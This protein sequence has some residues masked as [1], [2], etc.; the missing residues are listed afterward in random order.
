MLIDTTPNLIISLSDFISFTIHFLRALQILHE[1]RIVHTR[2]QSN[3]IY[4]PGF[5]PRIAYF[6]QFL[7]LDSPFLMK[8]RNNYL[9]LESHIL[10]PPEINY[11]RCVN[12]HTFINFYHRFIKTHAHVGNYYMDYFTKPK[13]LQ[14]FYDFKQEIRE[15]NECWKNYLPSIDIYRFALIIQYKILP[16]VKM[17]EKSRNFLHYQFLFQATNPFY[18]SRIKNAKDL[19][20]LFE[21]Y[22]LEK[23]II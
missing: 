5:K 13:L 7:Y 23:Y 9:S 20:I 22:V 12:D 15:K 21:K 6:S 16:F 3:N 8:E 1:A 18:F 17:S 4:V 10:D 2:L 19:C 11:C 14:T